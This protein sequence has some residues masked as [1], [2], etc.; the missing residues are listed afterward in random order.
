MSGCL[1]TVFFRTQIRD[2]L[3]GLRQVWRAG[4]WVRYILSNSIGDK[5]VRFWDTKTS[6]LLKTGEGATL[7]VFLDHTHWVLC[8]KWSHDSD[9]LASGGMDSNICIWDRNLKCTIC[10]RGHTKWITSLAWEPKES[11][12]LLVS[13]S[14]DSTAR[15]WNA[16]SGEC[17][18]VLSQHTDS[19]TSVKWST[20]GLIFTSSRDRT[21]KMWTPQVCVLPTCDQFRAIC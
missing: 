5:T 15:V 12:S 14:K 17:I 13:G 8:V 16:R 9:L 4:H 11:S 6:T 21:I 3:H 1:T 18:S 19:V 2:P 7:F 20:N 10:L